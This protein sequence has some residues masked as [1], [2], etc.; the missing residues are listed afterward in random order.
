MTKLHTLPDGSI[1]WLEYLRITRKFLEQYP[2]N[3]FD[4]SS[5]DAGPEFIVALR[6][7]VEQLD[8]RLAGKH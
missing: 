4:G 6:A 1:G 8:G 7:A 3:I 2:E 5:G